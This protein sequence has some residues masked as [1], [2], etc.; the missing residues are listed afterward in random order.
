MTPSTAFP[1]GDSRPGAYDAQ[2]QIPAAK[3]GD[4]NGCHTTTPTFAAN[5]TAGKPGN[6]VPT[7]APCV[8]CHTTPG[9]YAMYDSTGTHQGVSGCVQCHGSSAFNLPPT[10]SSR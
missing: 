4:C 5:V 6:H 7:S 9:N 8:Q 1:G 2:H 10:L 3:S